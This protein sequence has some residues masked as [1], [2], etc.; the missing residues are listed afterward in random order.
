MQE[1]EV[2]VMA[3]GFEAQLPEAEYLNRAAMAISQAAESMRR[4]ILSARGKEGSVRLATEVIMAMQAQI[5]AAETAIDQA[6]DVARDRDR[7]VALDEK[8]RPRLIRL[9]RLFQ[10]LPDL[11][12][13]GGGIAVLTA[14]QALM[15][16]EELMRALGAVRQA[17]IDHLALL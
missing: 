12:Q 16:F 5:K 10:D 4:Q 14:E 3:G 11:A 6:W 13:A 7:A 9:I 17:T 8:L 2:S 1:N 15:R